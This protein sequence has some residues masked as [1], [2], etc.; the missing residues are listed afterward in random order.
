MIKMEKSLI[1]TLNDNN[2]PTKKIISILSYLRGGPTTLPVKKK[3]MSNFITKL[4]REIR[5]TDMTKVLDSF[6]IKKSEDS[7]FFYKFELDDDNKVK[8][9]FWRD[10]SSLKYKDCVSFDTTYMTNKYRLPFAPF[11]GITGHGHACIFGCAFLHDDTT[12]IFRW[13]FETFLE[14]MGGKHPQ[15]IITD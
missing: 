7:T 5:G 2:I 12:A 3:D 10:G 14:S 11:V 15:T 9:I 4:N 1:R 8:N 6:R 13:V